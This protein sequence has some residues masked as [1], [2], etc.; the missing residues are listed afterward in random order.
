M[1]SNYII[2]VGVCTTCRQITGNTVF[3]GKIDN[4][5][6]SIGIVK[7]DNGVAHFKSIVADGGNSAGNNHALQSA[8]TLESTACNT[9]C[10]I[11]EFNGI[12]I[13]CTLVTI[14]DMI[15][16][17]R[18]FGLHIIPLSTGQNVSADFGQCFGN[19]D[20]FQS[21]TTTESKFTNISNVIGN[22]Y[23]NN[24][25]VVGVQVL[26]NSSY[27]CADID[28]LELSTSGE[29]T[30][31][32]GTTFS[33]IVKSFQR[34]TVG[35]CAGSNRG[36]IFRDGQFCQTATAVYG[37]QVCRNVFNVFAQFNFAEFV[38]VIKCITCNIGA[39]YSIINNALNIVATIK[40]TGF[41]SGNRLRNFQ[42]SQIGIGSAQIGRNG[43]NVLTENDGLHSSTAES[44]G[45][46]RC[47]SRIITDNYQRSTVCKSTAS[48]FG[49]GGRN[50]YGHQITAICKS[51]GRNNHTAGQFNVHQ[52]LRHQS[53]IALGIFTAEQIAQYGSSLTIGSSTHIRNFNCRNI[54]IGQYVGTDVLNSTGNLNRYN[55][56]I[57]LPGTVSDVGYFCRNYDLL[58]ITLI[59]NIY[60][61]Q[62]NG[63]V[64]LICHPFGVF[65]SVFANSVQVGAGSNSFQS[66]T[67][68]KS[69][70]ADLGSLTVADVD[71]LQ[72]FTTVKCLGTYCAGFYSEVE[73]FKSRTAVKCIG[74]QCSNSFVKGYADQIL[75]T[76]KNRSFDGSV[77]G[78]SNTCQSGRETGIGRIGNTAK[79]S[80]HIA[81]IALSG[82]DSSNSQFSQTVTTC[83]CIDTDA[84]SSVQ[85]DFLQSGATEKSGIAHSVSGRHCDALQC[86]AILKCCVADNRNIGRKYNSGGGTANKSLVAD[87]C[88]RITTQCC[89]NGNSSISTCIGSDGYRIFLGNSVGVVPISSRKSSTDLTNCQRRHHQQHAKDYG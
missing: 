70:S 52:C 14:E 6:G 68:F 37:E 17:N 76:C 72:N 49:N 75:H 66:G 81:N 42:S 64:S 5:F 1:L 7:N 69:G 9:Y 61:L 33:V 88:N 20:L 25:R 24:R 47:L 87:G 55:V 44:I 21:G 18:T 10:A 40:G 11:V 89:R 62:Q 38:T 56:F 80:S 39:V 78:N 71:C 30:V 19:G 43:L 29:S 73:V 51:A 28:V 12:A 45:C 41:N 54:C 15:Q 46:N 35:E 3:V 65:E 63:T 32:D 34:N 57:T 86:S 13:H 74:T 4:C 50:G 23:F 77:I 53:G 58:S 22:S 85:I 59:G 67:T 27:V 16:I 48:D 83:Q 79:Q 84:L 36:N 8:V 2:G 26:G 31:A 60:F 82:T